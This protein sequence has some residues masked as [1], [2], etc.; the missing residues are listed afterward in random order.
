MAVIEIRVDRGRS[1]RP[2][3]RLLR[4]RRCD[5]R[6]PELLGVALERVS[7]LGRLLRGCRPDE[8]AERPVGCTSERGATPKR[9]NLHPSTRPKG[10]ARRRFGYPRIQIPR[11]RICDSAAFNLF[12]HAVSPLFLLGLSV[13]PSPMLCLAC[14]ACLEYEQIQDAENAHAVF[15]RDARRAR[16]LVRRVARALEGSRLR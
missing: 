15:E 8:P 2:A 1:G 14:I 16:A 6:W 13:P 11:I 5:R 9:S 4:R 12:V 3:S 10:R 7:D